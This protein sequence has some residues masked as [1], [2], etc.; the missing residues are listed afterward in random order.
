MCH[1]LDIWIS[2]FDEG[3]G[4]RQKRIV[5]F[6]AE[7][8]HNV[9]WSGLVGVKDGHMTV[10][11]AFNIDMEEAWRRGGLKRVIISC[12]G[13]LLHHGIRSGSFGFGFGFWNRGGTKDV[14]LY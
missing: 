13:L 6:A 11:K 14:D 5:R 2:S 1:I 9:D 8:L 7:K 3:V 10:N 12:R 4:G